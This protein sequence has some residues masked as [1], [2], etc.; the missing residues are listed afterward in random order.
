[1]DISPAPIVRR[2]LSDEVFDRLRQ[3]IESGQLRAGD[4]MP[5]ERELMERFGVGRPA[6]REAMQSLANMG[7]V[8]ISHG[9]R[10]RVQEVT[11]QSIMRQ[12][13]LSA[14]IMLQ[15]SS[16]SL[17]HLKAARLLFERGMVREAAA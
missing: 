10:A 2:K 16:S 8:S 6:I 14:H 17:E 11:A 1:M 4:E 7:L 9:E 13:D 15:R 12:V 5:S 3:L